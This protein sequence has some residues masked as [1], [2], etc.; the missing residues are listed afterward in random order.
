MARA[1][2]KTLLTNGRTANES[3]EVAFRVLLPTH[4]V[5]A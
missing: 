1:D 5:F 4:V 2:Q 3:L